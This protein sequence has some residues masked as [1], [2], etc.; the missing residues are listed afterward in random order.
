MCKRIFKAAVCL[1]ALQIQ[2]V[3]CQTNDLT[4]AMH[5]KVEH[6]LIADPQRKDLDEIQKASASHSKEELAT[7]L[8]ADFDVDRGTPE[9]DR[10]RDNAVR[11]LYEALDLPPGFVCNELEREHSPQRKA[12]LMTVLRGWNTPEVTT[13]LLNQINDR[14]PAVDYIGWPEEPLEALRV[15]DV[16]YNT[17]VYNVTGGTLTGG[18][19]WINFAPGDEHRDGIIKGTLKELKLNG[20]Q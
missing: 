3:L 6:F 8:I 13:A 1:I 12:R 10:T 9:K 14:R 2:H 20:Q 4:Q 18:M 5:E 15:C 19:Q 17:L 11:K 7:A 16:A